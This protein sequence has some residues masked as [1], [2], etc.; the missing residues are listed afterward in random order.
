MSS[1]LAILASLAVAALIPAAAHASGVNKGTETVTAG[2]VAA[3][4]SWDGGDDGPKNTRLTISRAGTPV[5]DRT[6]PRVCGNE[7]GRFIGDADAFQLID[8]DGDGEPEVV[9]SNTFGDDSSQR[10]GIYGFTA[11][12]GTYSEL[13]KNW[14][15]ADVSIKDADGNGTTELITSD[16]RFANLVPGNTSIFF[17]PIVYGYEHPGGVPGLVDRTRT[18]LGVVRAAAA[19]LKDVLDVLDKHDADVYSKMWIGSYVAEEFMLGRGKTGLKEIDRQT[20]RGVLGSP[21]SARKFRK[22]LLTLLD[23]YGYR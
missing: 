22:R 13:V 11:Q 1:K 21:A 9:E 14:G 20:K 17:P 10:M 18:S 3:T 6:I 5:F 7:C 16:M 8:L 15:E 19:D 4:L 23:R 12:T 2:T